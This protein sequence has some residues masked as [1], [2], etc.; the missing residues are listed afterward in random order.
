MKR[1]FK[2]MSTNPLSDDGYGVMGVDMYWTMLVSFENTRFSVR[3]QG[4]GSG[5]VDFSTHPYYL[6]FEPTQEEIEMYKLLFPKSCPWFDMNES[7]LYSEFCL[8]RGHAFECIKQ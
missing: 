6:E 1:I 5:N 8:R 3:L 4:G 7:E 2:R